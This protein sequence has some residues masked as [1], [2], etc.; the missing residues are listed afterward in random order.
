VSAQRSPRSPSEGRIRRSLDR[1]LK[2]N[3]LCAVATVGTRGRAHVHICYFAASRDLELIFLS[4]P[5]S[6]HAT[7]L[8]R[9]PSA[10][11]A[12]FSPDQSWGGRDRGAQLFGDCAVVSPGG[13]ERARRIYAARFPEV[14]MNP[15]V[16]ELAFY[17]FVTRRVTVLDEREFGDA[18]L[19][20]LST[21]RRPGRRARHV[22]RR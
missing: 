12:V 1:I 19:V 14:A 18:V 15:T 16:R 10:A 9:R 11:I 22:T 6:R 4:D 7:N 20:K 21:G 8:R 2:Q 5:K 17:R 13:K 3:V